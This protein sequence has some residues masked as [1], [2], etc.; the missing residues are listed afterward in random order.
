VSYYREPR[1]EDA[2]ATFSRGYG[3]TRALADGLDAGR[4]DAL[5][6]DFTAFHARFATSLGICVPRTYL[7]TAGVRA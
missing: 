1:A 5:R 3:P 6:E 2:W 4:R 7:L